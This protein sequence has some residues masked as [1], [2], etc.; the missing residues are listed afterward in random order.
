M[1]EADNLLLLEHTLEGVTRSRPTHA[2]ASGSGPPDKSKRLQKQ[3]SLKAAA[4]P[5]RKQ[6]T[7]PHIQERLV[8]QGNG[9]CS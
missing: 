5:S 1:R 4:K 8:Q 7:E 2:N 3:M 9:H 6:N